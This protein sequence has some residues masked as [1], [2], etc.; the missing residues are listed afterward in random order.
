MH[1]DYLFLKIM[2]QCECHETT[3]VIGNQIIYVRQA[4]ISLPDHAQEKLGPASLQ[5]P[6]T[7]VPISICCC[8][9]IGHNVPYLSHKQRLLSTSQ[10]IIG[11]Y[12]KLLP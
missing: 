1:A 5:K 3:I 10:A 11:Q 2:V 12:L 9:F 7:A 4:K 6:E 8:C